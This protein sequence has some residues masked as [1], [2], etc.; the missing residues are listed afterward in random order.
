MK[1]GSVLISP[2]QKPPDVSCSFSNDS[3]NLAA[4]N[5]R[6]GVIGRSNRHGREHSDYSLPEPFVDRHKI[7]WNLR[8]PG[9]GER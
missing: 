2:R 8:K 7:E 3:V 4:N 9:A 6:T 5:I 1:P